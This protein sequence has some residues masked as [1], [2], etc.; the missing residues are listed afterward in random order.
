MCLFVFTGR[1]VEPSDVTTFTTPVPGPDPEPFL[2]A[3]LSFHSLGTLLV[4]NVTLDMANNIVLRNDVNEATGNFSAVLT[5]R[6][7]VG[8]IDPEM[9]LTA[10]Q[11]FFNRL[12]NNTEGA[13]S[14][15]LGAGAGNITTVTAPAVQIVNG[16]DADRDGL[17][18]NPLE[19][20]L[21]QS[22]QAGDDEL[23]I[24]FT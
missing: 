7:P 6:N 10:T 5:G 16:S 9:I 15:I 24:A 13:L 11:N 12:T 20:Q 4:Q 22:T 14:Y 1:Y 17:R 21:N 2:N 23:S 18:T 19:L 3:T 8:S